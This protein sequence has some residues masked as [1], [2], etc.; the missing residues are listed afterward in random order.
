MLVGMTCFN[1]ILS[2]CMHDCV[3]NLL[4]LFLICFKILYKKILENRRNEYNNSNN[5]NNNN[6]KILF[7][8]KNYSRDNIQTKQHSS[9]TFKTI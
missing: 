9:S 3:S 8:A 5:N 6:E 1:N 7:L 4:F 2:E